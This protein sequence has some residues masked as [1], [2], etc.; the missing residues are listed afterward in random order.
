[1]EP[2]VAEPGPR[3]DTLVQELGHGEP[4]RSSG[5][6]EAE[7]KTCC[8]A[9]KVLRNHEVLLKSSE[10]MREGDLGWIS[11]KLLMTTR[12]ILNLK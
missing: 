5:L 12:F 2:T 10:T 9:S 4:Q 7:A 1:M 11:R 8:S 6:W 3:G